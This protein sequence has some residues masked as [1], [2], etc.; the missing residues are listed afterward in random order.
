MASGKSSRDIIVGS[1]AAVAP[2][3]NLVARAMRNTFA[4]TACANEGSNGERRNELKN[5]AKRKKALQSN[6]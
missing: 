1:A 2:M 6:R 5:N 3:R 4:G